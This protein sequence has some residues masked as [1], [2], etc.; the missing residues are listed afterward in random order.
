M[1]HKFWFPEA[2]SVFQVKSLDWGR[3]CIF[4]FHLPSVSP[5][6]SLSCCFPK[7]TCELIHHIYSLALH[8][9]NE[10]LLN[11]K[12]GLLTIVLQATRQGRELAGGDEEVG[13]FVFLIGFFYVKVTFSMWRLTFESWQMEDREDLSPNSICKVT[14][15]VYGVIRQ[16]PA[17]SMH[18]YFIRVQVLHFMKS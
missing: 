3:V 10:W 7:C 18:T 8:F 9:R 1:A 11:S 5:S 15:S 6:K 2:S 14:H 17:L 13:W 16:F 4:I 12:D